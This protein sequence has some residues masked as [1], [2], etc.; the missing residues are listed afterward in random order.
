MLQTV[1]KNN[2]DMKEDQEKNP[3]PESPKGLQTKTYQPQGQLQPW[4]HTPQIVLHTSTINRA[5]LRSE[6][7]VGST[8]SMSENYLAALLA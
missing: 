4:R 7:S 6:R 2:R 1:P 8:M 3:S 5:T